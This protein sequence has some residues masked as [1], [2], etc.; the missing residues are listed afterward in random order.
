M[1]KLEDYEIMDLFPTQPVA[2]PQVSP[3]GTKVLFTYSTVN[4]EDD[5]YD[6]H[7]WLLALGERRPRQ[8]TFGKENATNPRWSP[9][10][11]SILFTS[12]RPSEGDKEEDE[13]KKAQLFVIPADGG[14][15]SSCLPSSRGRRRRRTA[16]SRSSGA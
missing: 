13:K 8:F 11:G 4:M 2:D 14:T 1:K 3:D 5:K 12:S 7:V 16:T 9:D 15:S 10:G 6:T